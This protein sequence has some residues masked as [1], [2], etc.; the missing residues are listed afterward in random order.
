MSLDAPPGESPAPHSGTMDGDTVSPQAWKALW[1]SA[2]G[3]A[4]D[5][6]DL[7]IL[8]FMLRAIS[9]DLG[10]SQA[11]AAS[12]VTATLVGAVIGGIGFGMLSD[13]LGRVRV[14]TWTIVLF[15]VFTGLCALAQGYW[16]LLI[17]R[18]IA[19]IGLGGEFGIGM[20]LVAEAWP[21]SKRARASS[22]VGLGWQLGVLGAALLTPL[23]LPFVGWR[24]MFAIGLFPAVVAYFI[25][26][27]LHEPEVF[28]RRTAR[29]PKAS[30]LRLLVSDRETTRN[31]LGLVILCSVQNFG[32]YGVMIWLPNYLATRFGFGLT[33][34]AT[35]TA[36]TILGMAIGIFAFGHIADRVGRKPA[37]FG[38]MLGAAVMVVVYS[39]LTDPAALLIGGAVMGFFV[40]GML[41]G[42]GALMSELYP[43]AARATAQ[44]VLFNIGRAVGGFG[45]V[46]VGA[47]AMSLGFDTAIALLALLYLLD[48]LVMWLLIPERRG[49]EL[50]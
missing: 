48:I 29:A 12:L 34:S 15:A 18:T 44:N 26:Q 30:P 25:R 1:G 20:A 27:R 4:M 46:V 16:D 22:Y 49:S 38:Y 10:L 6:F 21:A 43:T 42:Y 5:G 35:W 45:P 17:Y 33:Q 7:L 8:G 37:F 9:A 36:V 14:L 13:R 31:S 23:L 19:G 3:Y 28:V 47:V 50:S 40:N 11:Q 24:G 39:R 32:Y 2:L 41:G